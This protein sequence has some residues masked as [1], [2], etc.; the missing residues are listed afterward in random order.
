MADH[1]QSA[2]I[3]GASRGLGLGLVTEY[4]ARGWRV[5]ATARS[6]ASA[7]ALAEARAASE[8]RLRIE[9]CDITA[10]GSVKNLGSALSGEKFDLIYINAGISLGQ[11][12]FAHE[13]SDDQFINVMR[14]NTLAPIRAID[15]LSGLLRPQGTIAIMSSDLASTENNKG[16]GWE[17]YRAS[18]AALNALMKSRHAERGNGATF[19]CLSPGWVKTDMGTDKAPLE[20]VTSVAG[21]ADTIGKRSGS[22]GIHFLNYR[23]EPVAW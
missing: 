14:T 15:V 1:L 2:L 7:K 8:D 4:V 23:N 18:K 9:Y 16:G 6:K 20:V 21:L 10:D 3:V 17:I 13:A 19:L 11:Q 12:D 5:V 22:Q